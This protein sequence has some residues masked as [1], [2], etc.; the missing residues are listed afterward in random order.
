MPAGAVQQ[1]YAEALPRWITLG[2]VGLALL[3]VG[4]TWEARLR[5]LQTAKRYLSGLR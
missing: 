4:V 5:N 2:A 3:T 1:A